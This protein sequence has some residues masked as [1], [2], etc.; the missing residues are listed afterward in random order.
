ML[1]LPV[2]LGALL[3]ST[4]PAMSQDASLDVDLGYGIYRGY[5]NDSTGLDAWRGIRYA[6]PPIRSPRWQ[7]PT[8]P[9]P[10]EG[11]IQAD[12]FGSSCPQAAPYLPMAALLFVSI[13]GGGYSAG[14][15]K[16]DMSDFMATNESSFVAV[17]MQY[18][19]QGA[20]WLGTSPFRNIIDA[21][22]WVP[23]QHRYDDNTPTTH[24]YRLTE[25]DSTEVQRAANDVSSS[26]PTSYGNL[27][28]TLVT[29]GKYITG[30]PS[31]LPSG[32]KGE[33]NGARIEVGVN[34]GSILVNLSI[35][36]ISKLLAV[37]ASTEEHVNPDAPQFETDGLGPA[38]AV[39][40]SRLATGQQQRAYNI[41]A[42]GSYS[43]AFAL[44]GTDP[45][46][47]YGAPTENQG[48]DLVTA[49]RTNGASAQEP[50]AP[51]TVAEWPRWEGD[52]HLV[53]NLNRTGGEP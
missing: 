9:E 12:E 13:H 41:G 25:A 23:T 44:H 42:E 26:E 29:D 48:P 51:R 52:R 30:P 40:V 35:Q 43:V 28:F 7:A 46:A 14:N 49:L 47:Y 32:L 11:V 4:F 53:V 5:H 20:D 37:Y 8:A 34:P 1:F 50:D 19:L 10:A 21:S 45:A 16:T 31:T 36:N 2:L 6:A 3:G 27:A 15:A 24:Y 22:P 39:N 17:T 18:R 38:T 33:V